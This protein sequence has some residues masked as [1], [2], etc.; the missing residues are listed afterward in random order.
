MILI[1][2]FQYFQVTTERIFQ[3]ATLY[4]AKALTNVDGTNFGI[5]TT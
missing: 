3:I 1:T 4:F 5:V 2:G